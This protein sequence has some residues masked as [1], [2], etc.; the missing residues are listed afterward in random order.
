MLLKCSGSSYGFLESL[1]S[2]YGV[3]K[4]EDGQ[5]RTFWIIPFPSSSIPEP[6]IL[7]AVSK[8]YKPNYLS[9]VSCG[10][11]TTCWYTQDGSWKH[12]TPMT[13]E[14][15]ITTE[16]KKSYTE[17]LPLHSI[18][19]L[20]LNNRPFPR[21]CIWIWHNHLPPATPTKKLVTTKISISITIINRMKLNIG[22]KTRPDT[23]P[24]QMSC[25][26]LFVFSCEII[27]NSRLSWLKGKSFS[28]DYPKEEIS[29][30][31]PTH[32]SH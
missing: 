5:E 16:L 8:R 3:K 11:G 27:A 29:N 20:L 19:V 23:T 18:T 13:T 14:P 2:I 10:K 24:F 17:M 25:S 32:H 26:F 4:E 9:R 1:W 30:V 7:E 31:P 6:A 22:V 15:Q 21:F 12:I 28:L